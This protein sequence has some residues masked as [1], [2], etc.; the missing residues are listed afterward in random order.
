MVAAQP[1]VREVGVLRVRVGEFVNLCDARVLIVRPFVRALP[2]GTLR[3]LGGK[4]GYGVS[5]ELLASRALH[6]KRIN[7]AFSPASSTRPRA[8]IRVSG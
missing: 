3:L 4:D 6:A 1:A 2:K 8:A 7:E 5:E